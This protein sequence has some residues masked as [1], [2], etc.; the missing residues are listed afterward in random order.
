MQKRSLLVFLLFMGVFGIIYILIDN[1]S[2]IGYSIF[3]FPHNIDKNNEI[4][5]EII[6]I[7]KNNKA[8]PL[9]NFFEENKPILN[10]VIPSKEIKKSSSGGGSSSSPITGYSITPCTDLDNDGYGDINGIYGIPNGCN[11]DLPDCNDNN[12]NIYPGTTE[13]CGNGIDED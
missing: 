6:K 4:N 7:G 2:F 3:G 12:L 11:Y 10:R 1:A 8:L 5:K 9:E 13:I